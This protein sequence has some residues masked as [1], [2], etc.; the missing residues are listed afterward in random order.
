MKRV[1]VL[2][3]LAAGLWGSCLAALRRRYGVPTP[4]RTYDGGVVIRRRLPR[5]RLVSA[6]YAH[7]EPDRT[8]DQPGVWQQIYA[9]I[10][11]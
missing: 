9:R 2:V 8:P 7:I 10:N 1:L 5:P 11:K 3:A 6:F 4:L